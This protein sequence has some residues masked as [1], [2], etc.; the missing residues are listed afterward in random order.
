[1]AHTGADNAGHWISYVK[2][3]P[4]VFV[5]YGELILW[6]WEVGAEN[7]FVRYGEIRWIGAGKWEQTGS[8]PP[9]PSQ[10][11]DPP[12]THD[13]PHTHTHHAD[14]TAGPHTHTRQPNRGVRPAA[15]RPAGGWGGGSAGPAGRWVGRGRG[16]RCCRAGRETRGAVGGGRTNWEPTQLRG[17]KS[18]R[19]ERF[20]RRSWA[21]NPST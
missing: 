15:D 12:H 17:G 4:D 2:V 13:G 10:S 18:P 1:M 9:I 11:I 6:V 16:R 5:R 21:L 7:F 20:V 19:L 8:P 14:H 3:D